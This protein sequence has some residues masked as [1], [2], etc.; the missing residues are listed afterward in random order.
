MEHILFL[1]YFK[2]SK[3]PCLNVEHVQLRRISETGRLVL[4]SY[5]V[6][7]ERTHNCLKMLWTFFLL[8]RLGNE[9]KH[10]EVA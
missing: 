3:G 6:R 1:S 2:C 10:L 4:D 8:K 9:I 5:C 7:F